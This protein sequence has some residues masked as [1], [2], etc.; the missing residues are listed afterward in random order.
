M[1]TKYALKLKLSYHDNI[2]I[3]RLRKFQHCM[4][5]NIK[6]DSEVLD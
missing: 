4:I 6:D 2:F 3:N 5:L 1:S